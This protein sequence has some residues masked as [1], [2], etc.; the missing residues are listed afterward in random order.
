VEG[1]GFK[2]IGNAPSFH[3]HEIRDEYIKLVRAASKS[4]YITNPY[5]IPGW[6]FI[7]E[8]TNAA[9]R[10]I[11]VKIILPKRSDHPLVDSAARTYFRKLL[12][13]GVKIYLYNKRGV[14]MLHGKTMTI[15]GT[16][17]TIGSSNL[18]YVSLSLNHEVNLFL[19][20]PGVA[21]D[22][23]IQFS[24]DLKYCEEIISSSP[25]G[26]RESSAF[27]RIKQIIGYRLLGPLLRPPQPKYE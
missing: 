16:Y 13:S 19:A 21:K 4:I 15:D 5:F 1:R 2:V 25:N 6:K 14:E 12:T 24:L 27:S 20:D 10:G 23:D 9:E 17:S 7:R 26:P 18:D 22:L 11:D 3:H 8:L